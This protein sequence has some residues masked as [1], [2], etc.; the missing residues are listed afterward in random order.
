MK[1]R[2]VGSKYMYFLTT[3]NGHNPLTAPLSPLI[4]ALGIFDGDNRWHRFAA[5][6]D[7]FP[8]IRDREWFGCLLASDALGGEAK[9]LLSGISKN[10][11]QCLEG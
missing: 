6:G 3:N 4:T 5:V 1:C 2:Y 8:T 11:V 7:H 9:Q 10:T